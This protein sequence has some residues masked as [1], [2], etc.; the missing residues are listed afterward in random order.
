MAYKILE[1][2]MTTEE[3]AGRYPMKWAIIYN[4]VYG[5][6]WSRRSGIVYC[7][8][9]FESYSDMCDDFEK[10]HPTEHFAIDST[11]PWLLH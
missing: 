6:G 7:V 11:N 10:N 2:N 3:L 5:R 8:G 9:D 1:E 4:I